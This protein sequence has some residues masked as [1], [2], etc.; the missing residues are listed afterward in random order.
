MTLPLD[1]TGYVLA[2]GK[3]SRMGQDKALLELGGKPLIQLAVEKLEQV[4]A[5]VFVLSANPELGRFAPLVPDL[6]PGCGPLGGVEAALAHTQRTWSLLLPVDLPF[7]PVEV[8]ERWT[9]YTV[10]AEPEGARV[11]MFT[12]DHVPQPTLLLV[13]REVLP[14]V[15]RALEDGLYKLFPIL[16][17]AAYELADRHGTARDKALRHINLDTEEGL[18]LADGSSDGAGPSTWF[19]NLNTPLDWAEAARFFGRK[20]TEPAS[21]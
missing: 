9:I 4:C 1:V 17:N 21:D 7:F 12:F 19:M 14:Y 3:S 5:E 8:L 15:R 10:G 18:R 2:G 13:H 16:E 20:T 6:H 11:S